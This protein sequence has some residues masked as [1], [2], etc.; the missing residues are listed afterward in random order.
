MQLTTSTIEHVQQM[1]GWFTSKHQLQSWG[2]PQFRYP[3]SQQSFIEDIKLDALASY[4]LTDAQGNCVAF[5]Q[6]YPRLGCCHLGRLI[7]SPQHRGQGLGYSWVNQLMTLG[8][9]QLALSNCSLFVYKDNYQALHVYEK[10]GFQVA[11]Y[12]QPMPIA[13]CLYMRL[14]N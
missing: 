4:S 10:L 6:F 14:D 8:R 9:Q 3:F 2:G 13:D 7:V 5:G 11:D 1:L 12:P